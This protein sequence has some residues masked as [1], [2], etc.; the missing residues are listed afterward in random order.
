MGGSYK[1]SGGFPGGTSGKEPIYQC[2]RCKRCRFNPWVGKMPW[3]RAQQ[4]TPASLPG[5]SHGQRSQVGYS[6]Q[7]HTESDTTEATKHVHANNQFL[8]TANSWPPPWQKDSDLQV[9]SH[10]AHQPQIRPS[11]SQLHALSDT[12]Q[13]SEAIPVPCCHNCYK[14]V[15][16]QWLPS[17]G[18][19]AP[20]PYP[21]LLVQDITGKMPFSSLRLFLSSLG[22]SFPWSLRCAYESLHL[23]SRAVCMCIHLVCRHF[24]STYYVPDTIPVLGNSEISSNSV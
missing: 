14:N 10:L 8:T 22:R 4:P 7:G 16:Y 17:T 5:E 6:P 20:L 15:Q 2:R 1:K 18:L 23:L 24:L 11:H 21:T 3:R 9:Y 19:L 12:M 13:S